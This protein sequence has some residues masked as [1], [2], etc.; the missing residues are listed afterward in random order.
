MKDKLGIIVDGPGDY[1]SL[2]SR[3][4]GK[5]KILKTDGPRG[6]CAKTDLIVARSKKQIRLLKGFGYNQIVTLLDFECREGNREEFIDELNEKFNQEYGDNVKACAPN[7]MI[8]NWYLADIVF[9]SKQKKYLKTVNKQKK[10]EGLDGNC[11]IKKL[12]VKKYQYNEIKHGAELFG[13]L[14]FDEARN[15]SKSLDDFLNLI[16]A[17]I[18]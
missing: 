14:R 15:N 10:Y 13:I 17:A 8:E 16:N 3:F 12:M 5:C 18:P 6:H 11:E 1:A 9:L 7:R 4:K 2:N